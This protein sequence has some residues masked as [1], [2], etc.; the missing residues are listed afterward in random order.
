MG[1]ALCSP[2]FCGADGH[3]LCIYNIHNHALSG[4]PLLDVLGAL[5]EDIDYAADHPAFFSCFILGDWN[6]LPPGETA[7]SLHE[8]DDF[9]P[10]HAIRTNQA[11][12]LF[13][14]SLSG[15]VGLAPP[16]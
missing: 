11:A 15:L 9:R 3:T 10:Q 1:M 13:R 8:P 16:R 12:F 14:L 4:Q 7:K 5:D 2:L 6:F